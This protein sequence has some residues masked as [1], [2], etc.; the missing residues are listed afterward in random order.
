MVTV[1]V[2]VHFTLNKVLRIL[3]VFLHAYNML[4]GFNT[5]YIVKLSL[6]S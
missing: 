2:V 6:F 1:I 3:I 5:L 4:V